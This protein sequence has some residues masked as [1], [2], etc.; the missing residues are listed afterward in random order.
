MVKLSKLYTRAGDAGETGL[1]G[2]RRVPKT[3]SQ[4]HAYGDIDELNSWVGMVRAQLQE[5]KLLKD[6]GLLHD[7]QQE[8]FDIGAELATPHDSDWQPPTTISESNVTSLEN[9]IDTWTASV[10][11]LKSFL[12]PGGSPLTSAIHIAR[13]VC[14]RAERS[15]VAYA[16][17]EHVRPTILVY[18]NRLSDWL[19]AFARHCAQTTGEPEHLWDSSR[20]L[21]K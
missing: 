20:S 6:D 19:F 9:Q 2:G 14:R 1:V 7:I 15:V 21:S 13:T 16:Q 5:Q 11:E 4:V 17:E 3:S 8:L 12:L 18:L 10:P